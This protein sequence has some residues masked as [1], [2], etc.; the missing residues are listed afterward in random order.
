M[1]IKIL[2]IEK[3]LPEKRVSSEALDQTVRGSIGRIEKNTGVQYRH[4]AS[5]NETVV[6][7]GA[8]ALTRALYSAHLNPE[9]L[10]LLIYAG[11]SFDYPIP[12]NSV[13][14]KS[15]IADDSVKFYCF[16]VD[17][18]C[19]SFLNAL[20]IANLYL[21]AKRYK[22]SELSSTA[23]TPNDEHVFGLFGDAAVALILESN[24]ESGCTFSYVGFVNYPSGA[25]YAHIPIGGAVNRGVKALS[26]DE[27]YYF[28]MNGK[29]LIKLTIEHLDAFIDEIEQGVNLKITEFDHVITHQTSKFGNTYFKNKYLIDPSKVVETLAQYGNCVAASIPLGLEKLLNSGTNITDKKVLLLGSGAGLSLGAIALDFR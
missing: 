2:S 22:R 16:D 9:D 17:S 8:R 24:E 4:H 29:S 19:L 26:S 25:F 7:M 13:L 20:D 18:T 5:S 14:I 21:N 1:K 3:Y 11:G 15:K 28:K 23:L 12:H 27:G 6:E 10:D